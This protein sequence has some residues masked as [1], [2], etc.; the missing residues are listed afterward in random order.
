[1][2]IVDRYICFQFFKV[3]FVALASLIGLF[4]IIDL[5]EHLDDFVELGKHRG[6]MLNVVIDYYT[7][8]TLTFFDKT[9]GIL[10]L[11]AGIFVLTTMQRSN[12]L[13]A[14]MAGG[15]PLLRI[16]KPIAFCVLVI[17]SLSVVNREY[18]IPKYESKL[19][20]D[21]TNWLGEKQTAMKPKFDYESEIFIAGSG[22]IPA[23]Q[24]LVSPIFQLPASMQQFGGKILA[25]EAIYHPANDQHAAGYLLKGVNLPKD[26]TAIASHQSDAI[27]IYSPADASWLEADECFVCSDIDFKRL[28]ETQMT[29]QFYSTSDLVKGLHNPSLDYGAPTRVTTHARV[30]QPFVDFALLFIGLPIVAGRA[31][32]NVFVA[33]GLTLIFIGGF[34]VFTMFSHGMGNYGFIQP[35]LA[36]WLPLIGLFPLAH[37]AYHSMK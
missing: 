20:R 10:C 9:C 30:V 11:I 15:I 28:M 1:M 35:A 13:S 18:L 16:V 34:F 25:T 29:R 5:F 19:V 27:S 24:K 8:R 6:G 4:I 21:A 31:D 23:K 33:I 36:A 12:E 22:V 7:P 37:F 26:M 32:R 3:L 14:V 2:S 17:V